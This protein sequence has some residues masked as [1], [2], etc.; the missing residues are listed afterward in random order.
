MR[1]RVAWPCACKEY[2]DTDAAHARL[3]V[4]HVF[5]GRAKLLVALDDFV[6]GVEKV[7][8]VDGFTTL[9]NGKHACFCAH[10]VDFCARGVGT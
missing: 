3:V 6:D 8:F 9:T 2:T 4:L 5:R 7:F 1:V 10:G